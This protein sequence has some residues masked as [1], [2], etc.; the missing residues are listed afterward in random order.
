M[1]AM[2]VNRLISQA[3][4]NVDRQQLIYDQ[5]KILAIVGVRNAYVTYD[6]AKKALLIEEEN[7]LLARENVMIS[8]EGFKRGITNFIELRTTQQSLADAYNRL[9]AARYLA[10]TSEIELLRL[11]GGLLN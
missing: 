5:Q 11:R 8:L 10:K 9:I 6:N 7:I 2:N 3:K 1:N 4:I